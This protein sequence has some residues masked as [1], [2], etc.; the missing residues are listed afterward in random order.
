MEAVAIGEV[1]AVS[2]VV[3][4]AEE[5][6]MR[7]RSV[8]NTRSGAKSQANTGLRAPGGRGTS[9]LAAGV[10]SSALMIA[11][12]VRVVDVLKISEGDRASTAFGGARRA[13]A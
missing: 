6:K 12:S 5:M 1:E 11:R 3:V 13:P 7:G 2:D 10:C 8:T 9:V 4:A